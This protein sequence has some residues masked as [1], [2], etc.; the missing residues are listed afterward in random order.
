MRSCVSLRGID[1]SNL[2][3]IAA[4]YPLVVDEEA[5]RLDVLPA[6]GSSELNGEVGHL[7]RRAEGLGE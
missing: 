7:S 4:L 5:Y 6:I 1:R 3:A 2:L